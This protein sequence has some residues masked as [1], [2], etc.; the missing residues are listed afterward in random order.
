MRND[1]N[2]ES[3][4]SDRLKKVFIVCVSIVVLSMTAWA[5]YYIC[6]IDNAGIIKAKKVE[7]TEYIYAKLMSRPAIRENY[8]AT[9]VDDLLKDHDYLLY[10]YGIVADG[11]IE[12]AALANTIVSSCYLIINEFFKSKKYGLSMEMIAKYRRMRRVTTV[13][14]LISFVLIPISIFL[15]FAN[16]NRLAIIFCFINFSVSFFLLL[17]TS[18]LDNDISR[19]N[20]SMKEYQNKFRKKP[21]DWIKMMNQCFRKS[22][23]NNEIKDWDTFHF[24]VDVLVDAIEY[25]E[26]PA[27]E[28]ETDTMYVSA[29]RSV[30]QNAAKM[31][32]L[33]HINNRLLEMH[34][35]GNSI[36]MCE[37][38]IMPLYIWGRLLLNLA[39]N[40]IVDKTEVKEY[41]REIRKGCNQNSNAYYT[42]VRFEYECEKGHDIDRITLLYP[43]QYQRINWL[44]R[45]I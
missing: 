21:N 15:Q 43:K 16:K 32:I 3:I 44:I 8:V 19:R 12:M 27:G 41:A 20:A 40:K 4:M 25:V 36:Y 17:L 18:C 10:E 5:V 2:K 13:L 45:R 1:S 23:D 14:Q 33:R 26:R 9:L 7:L 22:Y 38:E 24:G 29:I 28:T 37:D 11:I 30:A 31:G 39:Q 35:D 42:T 6:C 34:Y